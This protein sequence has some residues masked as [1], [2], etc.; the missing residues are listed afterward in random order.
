M[1]VRL[2]GYIWASPNT[3]LG[4]FGAIA[5]YCTGGHMRW[6]AGVLEVEGGITA[7]ILAGIPFLPSG[8]AAVTLGHVVLAQS[9]VFSAML[10]VHE[11]VHVAQYEV[12]GPLFLP[13]YCASS[14][15]VYATGGDP[16]HDNVFEREAFNASDGL[17]LAD[18]VVG[19]L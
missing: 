8:A 7:R 13:A 4:L 6:V 17:Q 11:R 16:Y 12:W 18:S 19:R 3:L 1:F 5:A 9:N 14:L 2:A 15:W 10:R